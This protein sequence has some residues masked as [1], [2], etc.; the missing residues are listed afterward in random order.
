MLALTMWHVHQPTESFHFGEYRKFCTEWRNKKPADLPRGAQAYSTRI[1]GPCVGLYKKIL[2]L[3]LLS[4][5]PIQARYMG[6]N[7]T[8]VPSFAAD[9]LALDNTHA[10]VSIK[11]QRPALD[12]SNLK[13]RDFESTPFEATCGEDCRMYIVKQDI[14]ALTAPT[15]KPRRAFAGNKDGMDPAAID[16]LRANPKLS[17]RE[18]VDRLGELGIKRGKTWVNEQKYQLRKERGEVGECPPQA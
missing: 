14:H 16:F 15:L 17:A 10:A 11:N 9:E 18:A 5:S 1:S 4:D 3:L 6:C 12:C 7:R 13:Q 8:K 2:R